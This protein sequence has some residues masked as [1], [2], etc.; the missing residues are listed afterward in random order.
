MGIF[1]VLGWIGG[2]LI[3]LSLGIL[4]PPQKKQEDEEEE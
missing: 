1:I 3:G 4:L 2:F